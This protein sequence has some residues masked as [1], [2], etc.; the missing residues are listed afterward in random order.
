MVHRSMRNGSRVADELYIKESVDG[1]G[2]FPFL[3]SLLVLLYSKAS[4]DFETASTL[5]LSCLVPFSI[6]HYRHQYHLRTTPP[7]TPSLLGSTLP[8]S[9]SRGKTLPISFDYML[10]CMLPGAQSRD[11]LSCRSQASGGGW[12]VADGAWRM[13][14]EI[15]TSVD[16]IV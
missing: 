9:L 14:A 15:M 11:L 2:G 4:Y 1:V 5:V 12:Q 6:S 7:V 10:R 3:L 16:I 13:V 8:S